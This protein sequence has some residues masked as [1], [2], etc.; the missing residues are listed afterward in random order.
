MKKPLTPPSKTNHLKTVSALTITALL[1]LL[2]WQLFPAGH[3]QPALAQSD[4]SW[5]HSTVAEF[6]SCSVQTNTAVT[7]V[8]GGEV[9][10]TALVEDYF[11]GTELDQNRWITTLLSG[12]FA[13]P[14]RVENGMLIIQANELSATTA[15]TSFPVTVEGRMRFADPD[16]PLLTSTGWADFGLGDINEVSWQRDGDSNAL[17]ISDGSGVVS[18]NSYQINN[19]S[20]Q[21]H[22]IP[23]YDWTEFHDFRI[24]VDT[25]QVDYYVDDNHVRTHT[26]ANPL[27]LPMYLWFTSVENGREFIADW[28]RVAHYPA[29]GTFESCAIDG[30]SSQNWGHLV[31]QGEA[32]SGSAIQFETR[33]SA[34]SSTWSGWQALGGG[35][36]IASPDARYLQ[37]RITFSTTDP[38]VSPE[39]QQ[40]VV[41]T[42]TGGNAPTLSNIE[43][44][45]TSL[46]T[47][48]ISWDTDQWATGQVE[49]GLTSGLGSQTAALEYKIDHSFSLTGLQPETTYY[50]RVSATNAAG[51]L[52]QSGVA[53][54]TTPINFVSQTTTTDFGQ[55][56]S[57]SQLTNTIVA[58]VGDGEIR[59]RSQAVEDYFNG[60]ELDTNLWQ[61][62]LLSGSTANTPP[63][64][65]DVV[66]VLNSMRLRSKS[67]Y[68]ADRILEFRANFASATT[69]R[70]GFSYNNIPT[71]SWAVLGSNLESEMNVLTLFDE[72][73]PDYPGIE[74]GL[75]AQ[76][77]QFHDFRIVWEDDHVEYWVDG[78]LQIIHTG[79]FINDKMYAQITNFND[80][81]GPIKIDWFRV[82]KSPPSGT[83]VSCPIDAGEGV[84]N[85]AWNVL[86]WD[87]DVPPGTSVSFRTRSSLNGSNWSDWSGW[88]TPTTSDQHH[89][90]TNPPGRYLQYEASF[91]SSNEQL[92]PE[93]SSV[94]VSYNSYDAPI[95]TPTATI[96]PTPTQTQTPQPGSTATPTM[97]P[98][99]GSTATPTMTPTPVSTVTGG[100]DQYKL[101]LPLIVK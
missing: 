15:I 70:L 92:V 77:D 32:P 73:S 65:G 3:S 87:G 20:L 57:C 25:N 80:S 93:L 26:L 91:S 19:G 52:A 78:K 59:L 60:T 56:S 11:D 71:S 85:V 35:G 38:A 54:F 33:T 68:D 37:Y 6:S 48:Q 40:V 24:V 66:E 50:Y 18:A 76:T 30:G 97:T 10:L 12:G 4:S 1:F 90:I 64:T 5:S 81:T 82:I 21:R 67:R 98:L 28:L 89:P 22:A 29:G 47:A 86:S 42:D 79:T 100:S 72:G 45:A 84:G 94:T 51:Q 62:T 69:G 49:Y 63:M 41:A 7:N 83:F 2:G 14:P 16:L 58:D 74:V 27:A 96:T 39:V 17:F 99:P 43:G 53:T 34:D 13:P 55:G 8:A 101:F 23:N 75:N 44:L 61:L 46:S 31:W 36:S 9:R 88:S 95:P